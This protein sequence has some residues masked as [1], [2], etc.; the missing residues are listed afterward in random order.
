M[1]HNFHNE[2]HFSHIKV[3]LRVLKD[4]AST[5]EMHFNAIREI[6]REKVLFWFILN[7]IFE[8]IRKQLHLF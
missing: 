8:L 4:P 1:L 6:Q 7:L 3:Q 5:K 2:L